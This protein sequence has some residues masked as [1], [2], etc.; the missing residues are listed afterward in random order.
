MDTEGFG[1]SEVSGDPSRS[2]AG[3]GGEGS[4]PCPQGAHRLALPIGPG[5]I[6]SGRCPWSPCRSGR[7]NPQAGL[8]APIVAPADDVAFLA[9]R[10]FGR[11]LILTHFY[12]PPACHQSAP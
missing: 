8:T 12:Y 3:G 1:P 6:G 9:D 4:G 7:P 10:I 2:R 5:G 11:V